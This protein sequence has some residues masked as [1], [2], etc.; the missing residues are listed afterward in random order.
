MNCYP[1]PPH[2]ITASEPPCFALRY[3]RAPNMQLQRDTFHS[4]SRPAIAKQVRDIQTESNIWKKRILGGM[5]CKP[6]VFPFIE[7]W[8]TVLL[9]HWLFTKW[10][11]K[12]FLPAGVLESIQINQSTE[13]QLHILRLCRACIVQVS[14]RLFVP[15]NIMIDCYYF[16]L[17]ISCC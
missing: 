9:R 10:P 7:R 13:R 14:E 17:M 11:F 16:D 3:T 2:L 15:T 4:W 6:K 8:F 5:K 1:H 12:W